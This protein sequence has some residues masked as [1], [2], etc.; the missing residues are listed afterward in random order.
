MRKR[1]VLAGLVLGLVLAGSAGGY[2]AGRLVTVKSGDTARF[3]PSIWQC[4]NVGKSIDCYSGDASPYAD[5][6]GTPRGG[7][8]VVVHTLSGGG[9]RVRNVHHP[10]SGGLSAYDEIVYTFSADP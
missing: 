1:T 3:L 7:V 6:T 2:V 9:V 5:L 10:A 4:Q 8:T